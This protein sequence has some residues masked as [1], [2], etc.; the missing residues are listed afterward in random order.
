MLNI[1]VVLPDPEANGIHVP[2]AKAQARAFAMKWSGGY[3]SR[4]I[5]LDT[6]RIMIEVMT[7]SQARVTITSLP[8]YMESGIL[9]LLRANR[10]A[11]ETYRPALVRFTPRV[12][13][14]S[15]TLPNAIG[16]KLS[17]GD[18]TW[19][20]AG[21]KETTKLKEITV[22]DPSRVYSRQEPTYCDPEMIARRKLLMDAV[23]PS[24]FTGKLRLFVQALYGTKRTDFD[25]DTTFNFLGDLMMYTK[26]ED[27][28][29]VNVRISSGYPTTGLV[30]IDGK[31]LLV[32]VGPSL[33]T[34]RKMVPSN[35]RAQRRGGAAE[36]YALCRLNPGR[37]E[38]QAK[39]LP[40]S[41]PVVGT[42]LAYGWKFNEDGT[43]ASIVVV[44]EV[45]TAA[46]TTKAGVVLTH[47]VSTEAW[48]FVRHEIVFSW[49]DENEELNYT[50]ASK[51]SGQHIPYLQTKIFVPSP[52][53]RMDMITPA[54]GRLS[55]AFANL[56]APIYCYYKE[57]ELVVVEA[58]NGAINVLPA[59]DQYDDEGVTVRT[60]M[61][62]IFRATPQDYISPPHE[63]L[64][65]TRDA[66]ITYEP[67]GAKSQEFSYV[68]V[69][70]FVPGVT[71]FNEYRLGPG[72]P[73]I[74]NIGYPN[75]LTCAGDGKSGESFHN[76][77]SVIGRQTSHR[78]VIVIPFD[79]ASA[80][81]GADENLV[82]GE[83]ASKAYGQQNGYVQY[84][85]GVPFNPFPGPRQWFV[86]N[87]SFTISTRDLNELSDAERAKVDATV[88]MSSVRTRVMVM[89]THHSETV[90]DTA[91]E[92]T[93]ASLGRFYSR[94][95]ALL[96]ECN[97]S[98]PHYDNPLVV[99]T[100]YFGATS[101]FGLRPVDNISQLGYIDGWPADA[102]TPIGWA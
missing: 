47:G 99:K 38:F 7:P 11:E 46:G 72:G 28:E 33:V 92:F 15:E 41:T 9:D 94:P 8:P 97:L 45:T 77:T 69:G 66:Q 40:G 54:R 90:L 86:N 57:D 95:L 26:D 23:P 43:R 98:Y 6:A 2:F 78:A 61:Q 17:D 83:S 20:P 16:H 75:G 22:G 34:Y 12:T 51:Q 24:V 52:T 56:T 67:F 37:D 88:A 30:S 70:S 4:V 87:P 19:T 21:C 58:Q 85:E 71:R 25:S 49:D 84:F 102:D 74:V 64:W 53:G 1:A 79:D 60:R 10:N 42:P 14:L 73:P 101:H 89:N 29:T 91:E 44:A 32:T 93:S 82:I 50:V 59:Y 36:A 65:V 39:Q 76:I 63:A 27:D 81:I 35:R 3:M 18:E 5:L 100:S 31:Y 13:E 80:V 62:Q 55:E 68:D 96:F 48:T